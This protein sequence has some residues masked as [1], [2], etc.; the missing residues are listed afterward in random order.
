MG[1]CTCLGKSEVGV[2]C[3]T[4]CMHVHTYMCVHS[5]TLSTTFCSVGGVHVSVTLCTCAN[6]CVY[7]SW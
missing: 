2:V 6:G 5:V 4:V 3:W 1:V 7:V